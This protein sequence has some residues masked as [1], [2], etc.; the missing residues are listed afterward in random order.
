MSKPLISASVAA[1]GFYG[2]NSQQSSVTLEDGFALEATNCIIDK[3]GRLGARKGYR[4]LDND[5]PSYARTADVDYI[6]LTGHT[7]QQTDGVFTI[8]FTSNHGYTVGETIEISYAQGLISG[9]YSLGTFVLDKGTDPSYTFNV[10]DSLTLTAVDPILP[11]VPE[12]LNGTV[13]SQWL[14]VVLIASPTF[15]TLYGM[16]RFVNITG[17][18]KLLFG[19][20]LPK[21]IQ[22]QKGFISITMDN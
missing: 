14:N 22:K 7:Y 10:T 16:H 13:T 6:R 18:E 2:L 9:F 15:P 20:I 5:F 21:L 4:I 3:Y 12:N 19:E 8:V 17:T 1:P 11:T